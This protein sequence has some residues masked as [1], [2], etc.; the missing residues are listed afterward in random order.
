MNFMIIT[1]NRKHIE[2]YE[3]NKFI[4]INFRLYNLLTSIR[5]NVVLKPTYYKV[6]FNDVK[7][8]YP[9][10]DRK[11]V[12][13]YEE[14]WSVDENLFPMRLNWYDNYVVIKEE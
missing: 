1:K 11:Y 2:E 14:L 4:Y 8:Y 6:K 10:N 13:K 5:K 3:F 7:N 12:V 9:D